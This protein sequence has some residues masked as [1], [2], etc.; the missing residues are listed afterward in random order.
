MEEGIKGKRP[1]NLRSFLSQFNKE[2]LIAQIM[3]LTIK[4]KEIK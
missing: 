3:E 4:Y 2:Q 1:E